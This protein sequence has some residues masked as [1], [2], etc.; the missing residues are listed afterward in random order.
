MYSMPMPSIFNFHLKVD[1]NQ[2][3]QFQ[4]QQVPS[5]NG[6]FLKKEIV[7]NP[8]GQLMPPMAHSSQ[9][10]PISVVPQQPALVVPPSVPAQPN[11]ENNFILEHHIKVNKSNPKPYTCNYCAKAYKQVRT[12]RRTRFDPR[13]SFS[14]YYS[15]RSISFGI[16]S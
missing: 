2:Q 9:S 1:E 14:L 5:N 10:Q 4:L 8:Q 12:R 7:I 11:Q 13:T 15:E 3:H 6:M 16:S